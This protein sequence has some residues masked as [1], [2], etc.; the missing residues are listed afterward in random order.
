MGKRCHQET[1]AQVMGPRGYIGPFYATRAALQ[2]DLFG[3]DQSKVPKMIPWPSTFLRAITKNRDLKY[4]LFPVSS[5]CLD[6]L[7]PLG[8]PDLSKSRGLSQSILRASWCLLDTQPYFHHE[9]WERQLELV[10]TKS[11]QLFVPNAATVMAADMLYRHINYGNHILPRGKWVRTADRLD[12]RHLCIGNAGGKLKGEWRS[13]S[14]RDPFLSIIT[15]V[16]PMG[17]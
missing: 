16:I 8:L 7:S 12:G 13:D 6:P 10:E 17:C 3:P 4:F 5:L 11:S 9:N 14:L 2:P 15:A 1:A